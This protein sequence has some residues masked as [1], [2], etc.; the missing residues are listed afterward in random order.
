MD[1]SNTPLLSAAQRVP[2]AHD[3]ISVEPVYQGDY[4]ESL[5]KLRTAIA[6]KSARE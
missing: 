1:V 3:D 2:R 5:A 4:F 6:A